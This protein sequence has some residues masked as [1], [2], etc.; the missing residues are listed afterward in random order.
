MTTC[1]RDTPS[2]CSART[3]PLMAM[4]SASVQ[5][6]VNTTRSGVAPAPTNRAR[7]RR[8]ASTIR[9]APAAIRWPPRPGLAPK[10]CMNAV[11]P[12]WTRGGFGNDVAALSR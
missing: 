2:A 4:F 10:A 6:I 7:A 9:L 12:A 11:A 5:F 1:G 8:V 3:A